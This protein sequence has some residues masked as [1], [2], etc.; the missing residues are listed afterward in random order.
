[1]ESS[2]LVKRKKEKRIEKRRENER[3]RKRK[4]KRMESVKVKRKRQEQRGDEVA[5]KWIREKKQ[6]QERKGA[7]RMTGVRGKKAR[8][9]TNAMETSE[10]TTE[11]LRQS[12][13]LGSHPR[14]GVEEESL[15][16]K[17]DEEKRKAK[18]EAHVGWTDARAERGS[19][20]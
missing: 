18:S 3:E 7:D 13:S 14:T 15:R 9:E 6:G 10:T 1:M 4:R 19:R 2:Q 11:R 5:R 17:R 12:A 8:L 20:G 16:V